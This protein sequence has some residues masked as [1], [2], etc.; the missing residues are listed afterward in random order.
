MLDG[1]P[2]SRV[3]PADVVRAAVVVIEQRRNASALVVAIDGG[4]GAGKSTLARG[5]AD[6]L[7]AQVSIVTCDDFYRPLDSP[8]CSPEV[9]YERYFDW[10]R[11]REEAVIPLREH[12]QARYQRYD[13]GS[14]RLAEWI[15]VEPREII[16]VEGVF[17]MRP[18]LKDLIDVTIFVETPRAER[19]RRMTTRPQSNS[20][21]IDS[22]IAAEDWYFENLAPHLNSD[23]IV[24]GI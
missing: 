16:I 17:S 1:N 19:M 23:L 24:E 14:D 8:A 15:V 22:W 10:Q 13:W 11:L 4:G 21:W 6:A 20:W 9:A 7:P 18:E 12:R 5:I 2:K 3:T